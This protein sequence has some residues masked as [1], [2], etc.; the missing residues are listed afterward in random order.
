VRREALFAAALA[1]QPGAAAQDVQD[2]SAVERQYRL[3]Q[4]LGADRSPDAAPAFE[5]V[6]AL[7]PDGPF[8]DDALVD[9]A[10]L[11][12][13]P[14]WPE[15][16]AVL[17]VA[18][19]TAAVV[20]LEKVVNTYADG[21]RALEA[22]YRLALIR[23][24]PIAG[25]DA[26]RARRELIALAGSPSPDH[27]VVAAR[28]ALGVLDE[29]AGAVE[30]AA[31]AFAR[32]VVEQPGSDVV[33][34]ASAGFG[35]TLLAKG[36]FGV[37]AGWLQEAIEAGAPPGVR[38]EPQ[39][40]LALREVLRER[41]PGRR[42]AAA[43]A[44]FPVI[45][46]TRGASLLTTAA[47]GRLVVFDRKNDALQVFAE[48]GIGAPAVPVPE[49]TALATDPYGR[50]FMATKDNLLRWDAIGPTVVLTLGSFGAAAA[51]AVDASGAVWIADRKGDRVA[52]W[53]PGTPAAVL[54]RESKGA[55]VAA[56]AFAGGRVIAVEEKSGRIVVLADR[57]GEAFFG[58]VTFRRPV[59]L[60]V[61]A[62]GRVSVLDEKSETVTRFTPSGEVSD[63]L[64]LRMIGVSRPLAIAAAPDGA[65]RILDG[66]TGAVA[67]AP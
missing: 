32:I 54:V 23:M 17:D 1:L 63:T 19:A 56:L 34:R 62:S 21:D 12:G 22:R 36:A 24:A 61:D 4:R 52:R 26:A 6:V 45:P 18:R 46:T 55:G 42:W 20:R 31:G 15:E 37:A 10:R 5:K 44:P 35:R 47:D 39:R 57:G 67:V 8:A 9:L 58:T 38:A 28:Y 43:N 53:I 29:Q 50:V 3:A 13:L 33:P 16:V 11:S 40:D 48:T 30:R 59:A 49:V 25:R 65:I 60:A 64:S 41:A 27:W 2:P 7:A 14:D 51:I 66:S